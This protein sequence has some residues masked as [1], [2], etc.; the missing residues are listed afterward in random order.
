MSLLSKWR[1]LGG[2]VALF[3]G[4]VAPSGAAP[5]PLG[6]LLREH[7]VPEAHVGLQVASLDDGRVLVSRNAAKPFN[8]ASAIKLLPSLAAL[9]LLSPSHQW[10]TEV[11]AASGVVDGELNG[12]LYIRGGGD[13]YLTIESTWAMLKAVRALGIRRIAGDI[14][15]DEGVWELPPFDRGSFDDK[16]HRIYNGP[17]NALMMNFW[18]VRFTIN[19]LEDAVHIDAFPGS[20]RL[21]IVNRVEHSD[22]PCTGGHR[23][24]GHRVRER[25]DSVIVTF[26]GTLSS[27]CPPVII[28]RAVIPADRY[29]AYVLPGLWREAGGELAGG[30]RRGAVPQGARRL[31]AHPSRTLGEVIRATNKFSNNMMARHLLITLGAA[32]KERG[33]SV[34]DGVTALEDWLLAE[35]IDMP[36]LNVVNGAGLS[37]DTR[38][39]AQGMANLLRA[40][41]ESRYAP[42]FKAA[43]PIAGQDWAMEHRRFADRDRAMVR[44]KTGLIDHVRAMAAYITT[45]AGETYAAVLLVNHPGAHGGLG[46]RLQDALIR[47]VLDRD[48]P[49]DA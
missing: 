39:S 24:V 11:Y 28:T 23:R 10:L 1:L 47:W 4:A 25:P 48:V 40:G 33:A 46:T 3:S 8:P 17:A 7:G 45:P 41:H 32:F 21:E 9:E 37:R 2:L 26:D 29:A 22:G 43:F 35:G 34:A 6:A 15:I 12:N 30:V 20:D 38:V 42:E 36:G 14:V 13:P 5:D 31:Y 27:R 49:G 19:A 44:L 18:A 16:P